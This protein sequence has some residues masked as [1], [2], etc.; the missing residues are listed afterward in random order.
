MASLV[1]RC[2]LDGATFG[3]RDLGTESGVRECGIVR[4]PL[5]DICMSGYLK[6]TISRKSAALASC[7]GSTHLSWVWRTFGAGETALRAP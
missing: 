7:H 2:T 3:S 6:S 1:T 4:D 5:V